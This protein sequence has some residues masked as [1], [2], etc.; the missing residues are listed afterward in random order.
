MLPLRKA[1]LDRDYIRLGA[2]CIPEGFPGLRASMELRSRNHVW[3]GCRNQIH[4]GTQTGP[5]GIQIEGW[6]LADTVPL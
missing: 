5:S 6:R 2:I 1:R 4:N 3:N